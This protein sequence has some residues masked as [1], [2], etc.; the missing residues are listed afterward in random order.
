MLEY[1][2]DIDTQLFLLLNGMHSPFWD[3]LM[4]KI[5]H[6][7]TWIPL[8]IL[9]IGGLIYKFRLNGLKVVIIILLLIGFADQ[10]SSRLVKPGVGRLRPSHNVSLNDCIHIIDN[11]RGGTYGYFSSH[12]SNTFALATLLCLLFYK[13]RKW[14]LVFIPWAVVVSYSRIYVGVHY[15]GDILTGAVFGVLSA[16]LCYRLFNRQLLKLTK[17]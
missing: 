6:S 14:V 3:V 9:I 1:L 11:Y 16:L 13:K 12:A 4:V 7:R 5:T 8:Y 15:P 10:F 2:N 17:E